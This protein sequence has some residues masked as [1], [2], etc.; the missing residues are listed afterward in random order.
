MRLF[1]GTAWDRPP[2]C[3][4]CQE[5][6]ADCHCPPAARPIKAPGTQT[7]RLSIEKRAKGKRVTVVRGLAAC[8]NDLPALLTQLKSACGAGGTLQD[9]GLEIQGEH[10]ARIRKF[11]ESVG[12]RLKG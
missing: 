3:D 8:D 11:L 1:E 12:Y 10:L 7:A 5:L 6:V 2:R 9:E 4:N